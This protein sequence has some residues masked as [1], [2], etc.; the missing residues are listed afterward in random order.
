M[1]ASIPKA[2]ECLFSSL[3]HT[4]SGTQL[5]MTPETV[6]VDIVTKQWL[7]SGLV[8]EVNYTDLIKIYEK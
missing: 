6:S 2:V 5:S 8:E 1:G 4:L 3:K 7:K